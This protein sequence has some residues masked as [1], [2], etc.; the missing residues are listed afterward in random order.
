MILIKGIISQ[1]I[2]LL[3]EIGPNLFSEVNLGDSIFKRIQ[4]SW[5]LAK[6]VKLNRGTIETISVY[7]VGI[8]ENGEY[9][10][11]L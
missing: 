4:S 8:G 6:K 2:T 11:R 9:F 1:K 5:P 3:E 7:K 10:I